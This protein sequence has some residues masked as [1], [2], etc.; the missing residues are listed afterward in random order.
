M[1]ATRPVPPLGDVRPEL[2]DFPR[3]LSALERACA[4]D[5]GQRP[6]SAGA[7][8]AELEASLAPGAARR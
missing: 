4:K 6:A 8:A 1:Q 7:L 5:P 3:L 2:R